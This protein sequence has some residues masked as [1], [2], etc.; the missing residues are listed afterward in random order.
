[1]TA[2]KTTCPRCGDILLTPGEVALKLRPGGREG[3]YCFT[4]P[5][6]TSERRRPADA[7]V[8]NVLLATGV[9]LEVTNPR[10]ITETEIDAFVA[11][12]EKETDPQRLL[13]GDKD[14]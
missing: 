14:R 6:C 2:I 1:M 8:V 3:D 4:C 7:R 11:A 10:P 13:A 5:G 9:R 12:L